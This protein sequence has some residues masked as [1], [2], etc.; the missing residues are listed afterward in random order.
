MN[1]IFNTLSITKSNSKG[2]QNFSNKKMK[3]NIF[4]IT[5]MNIYL[6]SFIQDNKYICFCNKHFDGKLIREYFNIPCFFSKDASVILYILET[7]INMYQAIMYT[8]KTFFEVSFQNVYVRSANGI[9]WYGRVT[10][11]YLAGLPV[12]L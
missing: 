3:K 5:T 9:F 10:Q 6:R 12:T 7:K 1:Q 11:S 4:L 2:K 8:L